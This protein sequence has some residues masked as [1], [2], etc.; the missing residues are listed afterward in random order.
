[1]ATKNI[2]GITIEIGGNTT[3][4][5][6]ALK[7]V[8]KQVYSLNSD[9]KSLNQALKLDPKNTELLAQKQDV[10]KRNIAATTEKLNTLKEAQKQMGSYSK[11]TDEQKSSYNRLS[12][13]IAKSENALKSMNEEMKKTNSHDFSKLENGLKKSWK[14]CCRSI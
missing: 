5:Q 10:L 11:L 8:D 4:L 3:K 1:M 12:A 13:E 7:G 9:L 14:C 6:D 2:K